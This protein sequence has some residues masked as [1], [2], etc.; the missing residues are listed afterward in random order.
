MAVPKRP[1]KPSVQSQTLSVTRIPGPV[2]GGSISPKSE[3]NEDEK[4]HSPSKS[5][6]ET[7]RNLFTF[8]I[9]IKSSPAKARRFKTSESM[10]T[11]P[12]P[13]EPVPRSL[14]VSL[15]LPE[16]T[17]PGSPLEKIMRSQKILSPK[18]TVSSLPLWEDAVKSSPLSSTEKSFA[19]GG[20]SRNISQQQQ[21]PAGS[22]SSTPKNEGPLTPFTASALPLQAGVKTSESEPRKRKSGE[23]DDVGGATVPPKKTKLSTPESPSDDVFTV[24]KESVAGNT[25][26]KAH[27]VAA[28]S[29]P[30]RSAVTPQVPEPVSSQAIDNVQSVV[31]LQAG[32]LVGT[33]TAPVGYGAESLPKV[34][35]SLIQEAPT[36]KE[37]PYTVDKGRVGG[38]TFP[39]AESPAPIVEDLRQVSATITTPGGDMGGKQPVPSPPIILPTT[40]HL[41]GKVQNPGVIKS[42]LEP[43]D[44]TAGCSV[45]YSGP[46]V[47]PTPGASSSD[48]H[49]A[50]T[51]PHIQSPTLGKSPAQT[52]AA[53]SPSAATAVSVI[54]SH[55]SSATGR[56][57][58]FSRNFSCKT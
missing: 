10:E 48:E 5:A 16:E 34:G 1:R 58:H 29:D 28:Q 25:A 52:P 2:H 44:S 15:N 55:S 43:S 31:S 6:T 36:P 45:G 9:P 21:S 53:T 18:F 20:Q 19:P 39:T 40:E 14:R 57:I 22:R 12:Q 32:I 17:E 56:H 11:S 46:S 7:G 30:L 47:S 42:P 3:D 50:A 51:Q 26:T 4:R 33:A 35:K 54:T 49:T 13:L 27:T 38:S 24:P 37:Q 8:H 41:P 23:R